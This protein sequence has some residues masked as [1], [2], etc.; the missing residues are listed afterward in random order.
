MTQSA[1]DGESEDYCD[2]LAAVL[3]AGVAFKLVG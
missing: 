3:E 1:G 2:E